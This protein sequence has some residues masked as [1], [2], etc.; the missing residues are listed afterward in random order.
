[1]GP[2]KPTWLASGKNTV[3][4]A[5]TVA[6]GGGKIAVEVEPAKDDADSAHG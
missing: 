6:F 2:A 4:V 5:V 1:M 3:S